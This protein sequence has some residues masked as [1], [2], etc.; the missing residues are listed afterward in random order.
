MV[1]RRRAARETAEQLYSRHDRKED[2]R[3]GRRDGR[4]GQPTVTG[5][6]SLLEYDLPVTTPYS[7]W[8]VAVGHSRTN[9]EREAFGE[10]TDRV[11][12]QLAGLYSTLAEDRRRIEHGWE[13]LAL[14]RAA[15]TEEE[16][17][18][19]NPQEAVLSRDALRDRR[20]QARLRRIAEAQE[21]LAAL[22]AAEDARQ[23]Q[24]ALQ[25]GTIDQDYAL[26]QA[27]GRR[28]LD[29]ARIRIAGYWDALVQTHP[30][31]RTLVTLLPP[32]EIAEPAWLSSTCKDGVIA[33]GLT[34]EPPGAAGAA[35]P[36]G[37]VPAP[38]TDPPA[39]DPNAGPSASTDASEGAPA[40]GGPDPA[41]D[42]AAVPGTGSG[43]RRE[44]EAR[45]M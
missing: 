23:R 25:L 7:N 31:G 19:R 18:P 22:E 12:L 42:S 15:L 16:L 26:A 38:E 24:I 29:W 1:S 10:R 2:R 45:S 11:R 30:E 17:L 9:K 28:W 44:H 37:A 39:T 41:P 32:P 43:P 27:R 4:K 40:S 36:S 20:N 8:L 13:D 6:E 5:V 35:Q 33:Q 3:N 21:R 34:A 14:A